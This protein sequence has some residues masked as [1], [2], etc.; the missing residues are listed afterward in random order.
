LKIVLRY[1]RVM[2]VSLMSPFWNTVVCNWIFFSR[3]TSNER[4]SFDG[5]TPIKIGSVVKEYCLPLLD[6]YLLVQLCP[7]PTTLFFVIS[8]KLKE[9]FNNLSAIYLFPLSLLFIGMFL[10]QA[11]SV[12]L[13]WSLLS[14]CVVTVLD[15]CILLSR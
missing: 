14:V 4:T 7:K 10:V 8:D 3:T 1:D 15:I 2:V 13:F 6:F 11:A 5:L 12:R 9:S